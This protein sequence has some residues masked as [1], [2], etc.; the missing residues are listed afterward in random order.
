M[1]TMPF[2]LKNNA[3]SNGGISEIFAKY[4]YPPPL[5]LASAP[6]LFFLLSRPLFLPFSLSQSI[7][8]PDSLSLN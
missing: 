1:E 8:C 7:L 5:P 6:I 3:R 2:Y 4:F